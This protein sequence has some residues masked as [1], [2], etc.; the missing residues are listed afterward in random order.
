MAIQYL[1]SKWTRWM[2]TLRCHCWVTLI[3]DHGHGPN[4]HCSKAG[5]LLLVRWVCPKVGASQIISRPLMIM[6]G[7]F[8]DPVLYVL[9]S[10]QPIECA[11]ACASACFQ[12]G[13]GITSWLRT[14]KSMFFNRL[15]LLVFYPNMY[16][17]IFTNCICPAYSVI[18][19][20]NL[21]SLSMSRLP[22]SSMQFSCFFGWCWA[23]WCQGF[24]VCAHTVE[25]LN[26]LL[27]PNGYSKCEI[28][29]STRWTALI[30][31]KTLYP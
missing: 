26:V 10:H 21:W 12:Q 30:P 14:P 1:I 15:S 6:F 18:K 17:F 20:S 28:W 5:W 2:S 31:N 24:K 11:H 8:G 22:N 7:G 25:F 23:E 19:P 16:L 9:S 13:F 3:K 4:D 27:G 29:S